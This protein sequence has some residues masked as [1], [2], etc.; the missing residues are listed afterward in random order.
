MLNITANMMKQKLKEYYYYF[1]DKIIKYNNKI[2]SEIPERN[3]FIMLS[4]TFLLLFDYLLFCYISARN[5]FN[6]FPAI[7]LLQDIKSIN[8]YLPD[9]DGEKILKEAREITV[10]NDKKGYAMQLITMVASG[11][12]VD[13]TS[14][15]IPISIFIRHIWF[16]QDACI[17]DIVPSFAEKTKKILPNSYKTFEEC[18]I[19]T[20]TENIL[21]VKYV[22]LLNRGIPERSMW[23]YQ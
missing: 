10:H 9:I 3:R 8:I 21:S 6:I 15:V 18:I 2:K 7:P 19:K 14:E 23:G 4:L 5:P 17:V 20:I 22:M 12:N 1:K 11:S 13:N 16:Y